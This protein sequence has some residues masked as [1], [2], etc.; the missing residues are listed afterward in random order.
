MKTRLIWCAI[1][2][3]DRIL[4]IRIPMSDN[5]YDIQ[6]AVATEMKVKTRCIGNIWK[7]DF[8]RMTSVPSLSFTQVNDPLE[9]SVHE[10]QKKL[11]FP[12]DELEIERIATRLQLPVNEDLFD[13]AVRYFYVY[14][15]LTVDEEECN[16]ITVQPVCNFRQ[17][18]ESS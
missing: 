3:G 6:R 10:V 18:L 15:I 8:S 13:D 9:W 12:K 14:L 11:V 16:L 4:Q 7:V 2:G 1:A 17:S 5:L